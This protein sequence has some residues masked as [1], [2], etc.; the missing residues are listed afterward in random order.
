MK[1]FLD[2]FMIEN[3]FFFNFIFKQITKIFSV[4]GI[5]NP[6]PI[7]IIFTYIENNYKIKNMSAKHATSHS[8]NTCN[9]DYY[10]T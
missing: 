7:R 5:G 2:S 10:F 9:T 3:L 8:T 4:I 6:I 1:K